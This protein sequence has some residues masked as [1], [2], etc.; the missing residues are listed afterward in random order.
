MIS[1]YST[2]IKLN[3]MV[4]EKKDA[5]IFSHSIQKHDLKLKKKLTTQNKNLEAMRLRSLLDI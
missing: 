3:N 2:T 5:L 4:S 1:F